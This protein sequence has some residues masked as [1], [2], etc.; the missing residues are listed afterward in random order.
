VPRADCLSGSGA[1]QVS[2]AQIGIHLSSSFCA[3]L[4]AAA[5][6]ATVAIIIPNVLIAVTLSA[7]IGFL[8]DLNRHNIH[9]L[10]TC[11]LQQVQTNGVLNLQISTWLTFSLRAL[12]DLHLLVVC[13]CLNFIDSSQD[14]ESPLPFFSATERNITVKICSLQTR[15]HLKFNKNH[16]SNS[17]F[18]SL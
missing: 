4:S 10:P 3:A 2:V 13:D 9:K 8:T 14:P 15:C 12:N 7:S 17:Q 18:S 1:E 6:D 16:R 5:A 11:F